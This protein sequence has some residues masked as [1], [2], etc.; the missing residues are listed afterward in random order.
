MIVRVSKI[1]CFFMIL[2]FIV[3]KFSFAVAKQEDIAD[4][5]YFI[6]SALDPNKCLD[7]ECASKEKLAKMQL[8][9]KNNTDAQKFYIYKCSD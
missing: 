3:S 5:I 1:V 9:E 7:I 2:S 6:Q 8:Y 4:G